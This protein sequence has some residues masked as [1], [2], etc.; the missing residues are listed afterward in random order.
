[1]SSLHPDQIQNSR[2]LLERNLQN[3]IS[4]QSNLVS[5]PKLPSFV[6]ENDGFLRVDKT[7]EIKVYSF[8]KAKREN[9]LKKRKEVEL[10]Q[11]ER[12]WR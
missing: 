9:S 6:L 5:A 7:G 3:K 10:R 2:N 8:W 4:Y 11:L 12:G 1:M